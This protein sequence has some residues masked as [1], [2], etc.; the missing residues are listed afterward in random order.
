M[1]ALSLK[2]WNYDEEEQEDE[3]IGYHC[4]ACDHIQEDDDFGG[5]CDA[6]CGCSLE[7]IYE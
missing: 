2:Q 6:C 5:S 3:I 7:P 1:K 4:I